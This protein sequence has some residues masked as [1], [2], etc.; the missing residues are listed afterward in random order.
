MAAGEDTDDD[1]KA[2]AGSRS[3]TNSHKPTLLGVRDDN[4]ESPK[5]V[6]VYG[7]APPAPG[8]DRPPPMGIHEREGSLISTNPAPP[9]EQQADL[10][11]D[12][13]SHTRTTYQGANGEVLVPPLD[14]LPEEL[15][16]QPEPFEPPEYDYGILGQHEFRK[17]SEEHTPPDASSLAAASARARYRTSPGGGKNR[18]SGGREHAAAY[19]GPLTLAPSEG[20]LGTHP[21][22]RIEE[23]VLHE[24]RYHLTEPSLL[25][26]RQSSMPPPWPRD[27]PQGPST[28]TLVLIV[29]L[30][31]GVAASVVY[32]VLR[33]SEPERPAE[34][35]ILNAE[36]Q[37]PSAPSDPGSGSGAKGA[38][39]ESATPMRPRELSPVEEVVAPRPQQ[40][41][42][43]LSPSSK[44][45]EDATKGAIQP[46]GAPKDAGAPAAELP[47]DAAPPRTKTQEPWL[48]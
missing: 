33:L 29:L 2:S 18:T 9:S 44:S 10:D 13:S 27:Q 15:K 37:E 16:T 1:T 11:L 47:S 8:S 42:R 12:R 19:V 32:G 5:R 36:E 21:G 35:R 23:E 45:G 48:E 3:P 39:Q 26:R 7:V 43:G 46:A 22:V 24:S 25:V 17:S 30:S 20:N 6:T 14:R 40:R 34:S 31:A 38:R 28:A 41:P 4:T